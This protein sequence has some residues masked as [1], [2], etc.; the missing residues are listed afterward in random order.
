M[1]TYFVIPL[2]AYLVSPLLAYLVIPLLA[3]FVSPLLLS[4]D[5]F[6]LQV[7]AHV[8]VRFVQQ[9]VVQH[10]LP[11]PHPDTDAGDPPDAA[12]EGAAGLCTH[13]LRQDCC[14]PLAHVTPSQGTKVCLQSL[15]MQLKLSI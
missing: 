10:H 4:A 7:L 14:I 1:V 2:L 11:E 8:Q 5:N 15:F 6:P 13:W 3:Y 12:V 9:A